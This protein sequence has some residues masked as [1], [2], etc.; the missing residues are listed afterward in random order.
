MAR[1]KRTSGVDPWSGVPYRS[2]STFDPRY[3][4][5]YQHYDPYYGGSR[6][7]IPYRSY[8]PYYRW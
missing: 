8:R 1:P 3:G 5:T 6:V 4:E 2:R 7:E